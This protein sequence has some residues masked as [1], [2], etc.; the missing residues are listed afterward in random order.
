MHAW[1]TLKEARIRAGLTQRALAERAGVPQTTVARIE[2]DAMV[3]RV[4]TLEKLLE[5]CGWGL[6]G[7]QR[8][9]AGVDRT[10]I[11]AMLALTPTE[12]LRLATIEGRRLDRF[13][14]ATKPT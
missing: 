1:A 10:L 6:Y 8:P 4:D 7:A 12:R 9:G 14:A 3:P 11:K 2:S 5:S 13:L